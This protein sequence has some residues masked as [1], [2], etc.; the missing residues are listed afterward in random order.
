VSA[1]PHDITLDIAVDIWRVALDQ[2]RHALAGLRQTLSAAERER[3]GALHNSTDRERRTVAYAALRQILAGAMHMPAASLQI[4]GEPA[5]KPH[6]ADVDGGEELQFNVAHSADLGL[7]AVGHGAAIGIDVEAVV[8]RDAVESLIAALTSPEEAAA[9]QIADDDLLSAF[10]RLW[11][12]KEA[13][14]KATGAGLSVRLAD[15][16]VEIGDQPAF[17]RLPGDNP[18]AWSLIHLEP[19]PGYIGALAVRRPEIVASIRSWDPTL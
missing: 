8:A 18:A 11:T 10:Y 16:A 17:V 1:S 14:V 3:C 15:I 4:V 5:G 13:Y 12:R 9:L 2:P 19:A 7:I 6:L